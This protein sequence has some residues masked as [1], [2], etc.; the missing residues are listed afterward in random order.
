MDIL[1]PL[2]DDTSP[3]LGPVERSWHGSASEEYASFLPFDEYR[4]YRDVILGSYEGV[5]ENASAAGPPS[6]WLVDPPDASDGTR[7]RGGDAEEFFG[8]GYV[9]VVSLVSSLVSSALTAAAMSRRYLR[10]RRLPPRAGR[11]PAGHCR[12]PC[13]ADTNDGAEIFDEGREDISRHAL[14][15]DGGAPQ[16]DVDRCDVPRHVAV[17]MDG[18]RRYGRRVHG[19]AAR[20]HW[21]GGNAL[22]NFVRWCMAERVEILTVYAFSTENWRR[23]EGEV[24]VLM[25]IF[26]RYF[27]ELRKEALLRGIRVNVLSSTESKVGDRAA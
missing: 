21:E 1:H 17:I 25:S 14:R 19:S 20:G 6:P 22:I 18:N 5:R 15:E 4:L 11:V 16:A 3:F 2:L 9:T 24:R 27:D 8:M 26:I 10:R 13:V 12:V 23:S 7:W